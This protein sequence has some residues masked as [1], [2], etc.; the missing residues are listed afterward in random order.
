MY[1]TVHCPTRCARGVSLLVRGNEFPVS[2]ISLFLIT[3]IL[4]L[5]RREKTVCRRQNKLSDN[6]LPIHI[7]YTHNSSSSRVI[8]SC[9]KCYERKSKVSCT[10]SCC[11]GHIDVHFA[12]SKTFKSPRAEATENAVDTRTTVGA[13]SCNVGKSLMC[14]VK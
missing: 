13:N 3:Y 2:F 12:A 14:M 8:Q 9:A 5:R 4:Q 10:D 11:C 7:W 6:P 1:I